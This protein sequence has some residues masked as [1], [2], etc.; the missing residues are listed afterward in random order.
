MTIKELLNILNKVAPFSLQESYD[1][2]GIQFADLDTEIINILLS[3][4]LTEEVLDEAIKNDANV[5]LTH[6][7]ILFSP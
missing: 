3:L 2:S 7:P 4:D 5:I 6:H 1:N